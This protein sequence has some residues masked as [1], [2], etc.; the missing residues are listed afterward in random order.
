MM[1]AA[2][3]DSGGYLL[4][5]RELVD[6]PCDPPTTLHVHLAAPPNCGSK[7]G[8]YGGNRG[9]AAGQVFIGRRTGLRVR[10]ASQ[11]FAVS[12]TASEDKDAGR[13]PGG[14]SRVGHAFKTGVGARA[15]RRVRFPSASATFDLRERASEGSSGRTPIGSEA[16]FARVDW[17]LWVAWLALRLVRRPSYLVVTRTSL[18]AL[19]RV[20]YARLSS[21]TGMVRT[22]AVWRAYSAKPG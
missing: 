13:G 4:A 20:G 18:A 12:R 2:W 16:E 9:D 22:P 3:P 11:V 14:S 10:S 7:D 17:Y 8:R 19:R 15:P 5:A 1:R 21:S 6:H